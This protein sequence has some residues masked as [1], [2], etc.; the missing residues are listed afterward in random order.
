MRFIILA[1]IM[2]VST[3]LPAQKYPFTS[4]DGA[5]TASFSSKPDVKQIVRKTAEGVSVTVNMVITIEKDVSTFVMYNQFETGFNIEDDSAYLNA[6]SGEMLNRILALAPGKPEKPAVEEI[7]YEGYHG[8]RFSLNSPTTVG[9]MKVILRSNRAYFVGAVFP[10]KEKS[11]LEK[12]L[13]SFKFIPFKSPEWTTHTFGNLKIDLPSKPILDEESST[14]FGDGTEIY[15]TQDINTGDSYSILVQPYSRYATFANDSA[16]L[17]ERILPF[18]S[19][20]ETKDKERDLIIDGRPAK[21]LIVS[22]R[23]NI[24]SRYVTFTYGDVGYLVMTT[25]HPHHNKIATTERIFNSTKFTGEATGNLFSDKSSLLLQDLTGN[26]TTLVDQAKVQ[27]G[28]FE[29]P[30]EQSAAIMKLVEKKYDDDHDS[31][32]SRKELLL[33][34]LADLEPENA[35]PFIE[36]IFPSLNK[37]SAQEFSAIKVV[38]AVKTREALDARIRLIAKHSPDDNILYYPI[39]GIHTVDSADQR[40]FYDKTIPLLKV[41][42]YKINLYYLMNHLLTEKRLAFK[43]IQTLKPVI[44]TDFNDQVK[45]YKADT[46]FSSLDDLI[47]IIGT[48]D[49]IDSKTFTQLKEL[50][51][52]YNTYIG[53]L[54]TSMLLKQKQSPD[55]EQLNKFAS[56]PYDRI[57]LY[58]EFEKSGLLIHFPKAYLN[59]DS[60]AVSQVYTYLQEDFTPAQV[61]IAY[62][63]MEDFE[64]KRMKFYV[65]SVKDPEEDIWYRATIGPFTSD[66]LATSGDL[67]YVDFDE[68]PTTDHRKY[69]L[70]IIAAYEEEQK[71]IE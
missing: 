9:E 3:V 49:K 66:K 57:S 48:F 42:A 15:Y 28:N 58:D 7:M 65:M 59:Q 54:A 60:L 5:F 53:I 43:D 21:E 45:V 62:Q 52:G 36:K 46:S 64:G 25:L 30:M 23:E 20:D 12:F 37:N 47:P 70:D 16:V 67:N 61:K 8:R 34:A 24:I 63:G 29:F 69:L 26:D 35:A 6:V 32:D 11:S 56:D 38:A 51:R 50:S 41:K 17:E 22:I 33:N 18:R 13:D 10:K 40:Y 44:L 1:A 39:L 31:T 55:V 14:A 68:D 19:D 4:P 2:L 27:M 71:A